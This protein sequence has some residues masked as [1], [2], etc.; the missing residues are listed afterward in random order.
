MNNINIIHY[1]F[2]YD[3]IE[4][5]T[6]TVYDIYFNLRE[7][8]D[9]KLNIITND[10]H[11][12][13]RILKAN[14]L[15]D[16]MKCYTHIN[17][18]ECDVIICL[19]SLFTEKN[20]KIPQTLNIKTKKL[21]ILGTLDVFDKPY[22]NSIIPKHWQYDEIIF[23][24]NPPN[25]SDYTY[26]HKL[27]KYRLDRLTKMSLRKNKLKYCRQ[28]KKHIFKNNIYFENIGKLIFEH[29]YHSIPVIYSTKGMTIKDGL[30]YYLKLFGI[31]GSI[32]QIIEIPHDEIEEKL[33]MKEDDYI[34]RLL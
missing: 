15:L 7:F 13:Y 11:H 14:N 3:Y 12:N 16:I 33:I 2:L 28:D 18:Y 30:Y 26:Y 34:L 8:V 29:C 1:D 24:T 22:K 17:N 4:G 23:L 25:F 10:I 32:N 9:V 27:S 6:S 31:D 21:I 5:S 19:W 20:G